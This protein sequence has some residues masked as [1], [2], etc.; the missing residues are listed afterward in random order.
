[1]GS[2]SVVVA[3]HCSAED[4]VHIAQHGPGNAHDTM[5]EIIG[6]CSVDAVDWF[7]FN[8]WNMRECVHQRSSISYSCANCYMHSAQY[9]WDHCIWRCARNWC[10]QNCLNCIESQRSTVNACLGVETPSATP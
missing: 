5:P 7:S 8:K 1:M 2:G 6:Q 9:A 10:S 4:Q 3:A